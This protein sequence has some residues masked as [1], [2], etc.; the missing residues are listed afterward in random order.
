MQRRDAEAVPLVAARR[1]SLERT[2]VGV[3]TAQGC[4]PG[5]AGFI[6][7]NKHTV[8]V[9][10]AFIY[11]ATVHTV[12]EYHRGDTSP[13]KVRNH[14]GIVGGRRRQRECRTLLLY[15]LMGDRDISGHLITQHPHSFHKPA[16]LHVDEIVQGGFSTDAPAF[17][18]PDAGLPIDLEAVV[19]AQLKLTAGAALDQIRG[20]IPPQKFNGRHLFGGGDL[21][22]T[23]AG[24]QSMVASSRPILSTRSQG[25]SSR[26]K[27]PP[28]AVR[29]Y[30]GCCSWRVSIM[31]AGVRSNTWRTAAAR[32]S[33]SQ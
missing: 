14:P 8:V 32:Q 3:S 20:T 13:T 27:C 17:P 28:T 30:I 33:S 11:E 15:R 26:P 23:D 7:A 9:R 18:V 25:K 12:A 1:F 6:L 5:R 21:F 24:H 19:A 2:T 16:L 22:L 10:K 4:I 29:A 31:P